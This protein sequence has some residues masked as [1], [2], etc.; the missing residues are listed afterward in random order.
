MRKFSILLVLIAFCLGV[1]KSLYYLR[2]GFSD[3]RLYRPEITEPT[4]IDE[5]FTQILSQNFYYLG[6]GRQCFAFVSEDDKYVLKLPRTDI[7]HTPFWVRALPVHSYRKWFQTMQL[8]RKQDLLESF[9]IA[10]KDLKTQTGILTLHLGTSEPKGQK[11]TLVDALGYPH[12]LNLE[13]VSF[14]LQYKHPLLTQQFLAALEKDEVQAKQILDAL[15]TTIAERAQKR[16]LNRDRSFLRNYGYDGQRAFQIDIGSFFR[17]EGL[18]G[19]IAFQKSIRDSTD[20]IQEWLAEAAP[21]LL[22]YFHQNLDASL[23]KSTN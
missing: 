10:F 6:R 19:D 20:P 3:R 1:G 14:I 9:R 18:Q 5:E 21:Q 11:L 7:Y 13:E 8:K 12:R 17:M 4:V 15:L 16:V 2:D 22:P 23:S